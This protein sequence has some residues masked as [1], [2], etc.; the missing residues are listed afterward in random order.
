MAFHHVSLATKDLAATHRFYTELMGFELV[1]VDAAPTESGGWARLAFYDTGGHGLMSFW[2]IHDPAI[3]GDFRTDLAKSL[4]LPTWVNH[5]AF[6]VPTLDALES[7][8]ECWRDHGLTV[9]Q[10]QFENALSIYA[11][12]PNGIMVEFSHTLKPYGDDDRA[13]AQRDV[14]AEKPALSPRPQPS[15]FPAS[16]RA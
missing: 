16:R 3:G 11:V 10:I 6:D 1:R 7:R 15:F 14:L 12:D 9:P 2:E 8:K 13:R 5:L 4:G